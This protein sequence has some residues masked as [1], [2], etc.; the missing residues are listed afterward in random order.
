MPQ[1]EMFKGLVVLAVREIH[2][3]REPDVVG[4]YALELSCVPYANQC[5]R[6]WIRQWLDQHAVDD[7]EH[8]RVGTDRERQRDNNRNRYSWC[9]MDRSHAES[10]VSTQGLQHRNSPLIAVR[11]FGCD[12]S[13]KIP[14]SLSMRLV[15]GQTPIA[16][17]GLERLH[18]IP[19][20]RVEF[21]IEPPAA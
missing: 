1:A 8:R 18:V 19:K 16:I 7:A 21:T 4:R 2:G 11:L 15:G 13:T 14:S 17:L 5:I 20:L 3:G 6:I 9:W 10:Y 12:N